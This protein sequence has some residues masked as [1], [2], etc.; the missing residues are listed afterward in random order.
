MT[1]RVGVGLIVLALAGVAFWFWWSRRAAETPATSTVTQPVGSAAV[2]PTTPSSTSGAALARATIMVSSDKGPI[3]DAAVRF[4]PADGEVIV[5][6][7]GAD[8]SVRA[9]QLAPGEWT[10]SAS[11]AGFEPAAAPAKQLTAGEDATIALTLH[12]GG[13]PLTGLVTDATGGPIAGAR[14]DAAK[15]GGMARPGDAVATTV[16]GSDG[17]YAVTAA[18]GQ[19]LVAVSSVDYAAQSRLVEVGAT[20]A[21][22]N[23]SLVPGGAIEGIVRDEATKQPVAGAQVIV[24]RDRGGM[25]LLAESGRRRAVSGADGRFRVTSLRPGAY[26]LALEAGKTFDIGTVRVVSGTHV[27][28]P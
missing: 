21:V 9:D 1:K 13:R 11:A 10:I 7:T 19:V 16:T 8:G 2:Q 25:I 26:G 17:M 23:F 27:P 28:P 3:A 6:R 5:L 22:A 18:E 12:A 20:G 24:E 14:V 4:A 15:L